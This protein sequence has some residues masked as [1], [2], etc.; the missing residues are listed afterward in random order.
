M[1]TVIFRADS[2]SV[3][4]VGHLMRCLTLAQAIRESGGLCVF[5]C[6]DLPGNQSSLV[7][8][9]GF[10]SHI[11][12]GDAPVEVRTHV[13][14][15]NADWL[16]VDHYNLDA[17]WERAACPEPT[18]I[19]VIDDLANRPHACRLLLDQNLG[20][21]PD[22]YSRWVSPRTH[23]LV[24]PQYALLRPD[25]AQARGESLARRA[26]NKSLDLFINFG[27]ADPCGA[28][29]KVLEQLAC[30]RHCFDALC[31][32]LGG[33]IRD[34]E[35]LEAK[36]FALGAEVLRNTS[37]MALVMARAD[38]AIG[39]AGTTAWE[40]C[41]LG[42]PTGLIIVAENQRSGAHALEQSGAGLILG[43]FST[44]ND[45]V[46]VAGF[47]TQC[48]AEP[49]FLSQMSAHAADVLDGQGA[50]RV[51]AVMQEL[52]GRGPKFD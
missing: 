7:R 8:K 26:D 38:V 21:K 22:F 31:V 3:M 43:D 42:L 51:V 37:D 50:A 48:R 28:T 46:D 20:A 25:F 30:V 11:L 24:G 40:R 29:A 14:A 41:C 10:K 6:R 1:K 44:G 35:P 52:S 16:V 27:G 32:V 9:L 18:C 19:A 15:L 2:S 12:Q 5:L 33:A 45:T 34:P 13:T 39:A 4:G 36:A 17:G 49:Q 23:L 47:L